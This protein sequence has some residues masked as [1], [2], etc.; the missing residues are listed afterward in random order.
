MGQVQVKINYFLVA[1]CDKA[2]LSY[3][4]EI[5]DYRAKIKELR[6]IRNR[7]MDRAAREGGIPVPDKR[8]DN[9]PERRMSRERRNH[10]N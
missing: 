7:E 2:I 1:Q 5:D 3:D 9:T 8:K 6:M 4:R 10:V